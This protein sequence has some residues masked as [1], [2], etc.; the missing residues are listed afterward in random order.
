MSKM[1]DDRMKRLIW[2]A[3]QD[4]T[5]W[6]LPGAIFI[7]RVTQ[8][9]KNLTRTINTD[10]LYKISFRGQKALLHVEFQKRADPNMG[11]RVWEYNVLATIAYNC[12][13]YSFVI[14]LVPDSGI[15]EAGVTWGLDGLQKVHDFRFTNIK[16]W[17]LPQE[18]LKE[19][20]LIGLLP[21]LILT[22][23][24]QQ[25]KVAEEVFDDLAG[26]KKDELLALAMLLASMVFTNEEDQQWLERR[27]AMLED[28]LSDTWLYKKLQKE[29]EERGLEKGRE[30][31]RL[32]GM[33]LMILEVVQDRFPE[34]VETVKGELN[35]IDD[36]VV[37]KRLNMKMNSVKNAHE[38][39]RA[40]FRIAKGKAA[41]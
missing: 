30:E 31:G 16:L 11:K 33:R 29:G 39:T 6:L 18:A 8:E 23:G 15:Q 1:W 28:I 7:E 36:P 19:K 25:H 17:E 13:V 12:P 32:D 37:L 24:G 9:L 21:L 5:T 26:A 27:Q 14:Y 40:F 4:F 34:I 2:A 3:P 22:K 41:R 38:A 20:E 35:S 10:T